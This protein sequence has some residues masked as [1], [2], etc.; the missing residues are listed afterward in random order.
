MGATS[1]S[2]WSGGI[3]AAACSVEDPVCCCDGASSAS[4]GTSSAAHRRALPFLV[5]AKRVLD[6]RVLFFMTTF[7]RSTRLR[8]RRRR[9]AR[10]QTPELAVAGTLL[11]ERLNEVGDGLGLCLVDTGHGL[12]VRCLRT[13]LAFCY[14]VRDS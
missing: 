2:N 12:A 9:A 8:S 14:L 3:F 10:N 4:P 13:L 5:I 7:L 1:E 6:R 11:L